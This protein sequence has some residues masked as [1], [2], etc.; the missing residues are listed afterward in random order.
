MNNKFPERL[1]ELRIRK[2]LSHTQLSEALDKKISSSAIG[3]WELGK[4]IPNIEAAMLLAEYFC[5]SL[6]YLTGMED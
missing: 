4:R 3:Y 2:G 6:D 5:V 1:K